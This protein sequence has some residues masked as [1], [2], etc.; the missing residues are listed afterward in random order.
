MKKFKN[1]H[2]NGFT[3][4]ELMIVVA[5]IGILVAIAIPSYQKYTRRAYYT[6]VVGAAAPYK[7]GVEE[8]FQTSGVLDNCQAGENGVPGAIAS[9]QGAGLI[10]N[11]TVNGPG[12]ITVT[13]REK[14]GI[15]PNDTYILIPS[16]INEVLIWAASGGG[17][18]AGYAH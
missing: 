6:E 18:E 7:V 1:L 4:I 13:P 11:I 12:I 5:I 15:T 2:F 3:L 8:C 14:N 10:D 16:I 9:N 17:V